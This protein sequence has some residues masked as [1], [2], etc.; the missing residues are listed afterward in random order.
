[1]T[2]ILP[3]YLHWCAKQAYATARDC[4]GALRILESLRRAAVLPDITSM[5]TAMQAPIS[6][7]SIEVAMK[8]CQAFVTSTRVLCGKASVAPGKSALAESLFAKL[9]GLP[10][11]CQRGCAWVYGPC[12][13]FEQMRIAE[14][15][16]LA[17]MS[18]N[19]LVHDVL[20]QRTVQPTFFP[21]E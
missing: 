2:C 12:T 10:R 14:C 18:W 15:C 9:R 8:P 20:G 5:S 16:L 11:A 17:P 1:M 3:F 13:L 7:E 6:E 21:D 4:E 19:V